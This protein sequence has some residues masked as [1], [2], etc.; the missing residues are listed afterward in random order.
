MPKPQ[1]K[2]NRNWKGPKPTVLIISST[3]C[4]GELPRPILRESSPA[5]AAPLTVFVFFGSNDADS[6]YT[7]QNLK[8]VLFYVHTHSIFTRLYL[9]NNLLS[10]K[11]A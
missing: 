1:N 5:A 8:N 3:L 9:Q 6:D 11:Y 4:N 7:K 2:N 10:F